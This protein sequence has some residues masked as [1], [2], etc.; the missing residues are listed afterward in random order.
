MKKRILT[1]IFALSAVAA[2]PVAAMAGGGAGFNPGDT[3]SNV[4]QNPAAGPG[5]GIGSGFGLPRH[6]Q[7]YANCPYA[8]WHGC[9]ARPDYRPDFR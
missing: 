5:F 3:M 8:P 1:A 4:Y 7:Y 6:R 2:T 9:W